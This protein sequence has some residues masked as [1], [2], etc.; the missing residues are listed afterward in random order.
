MHRV[1]LGPEGDQPR[2]AAAQIVERR[3]G[4]VIR[5]VVDDQHLPTTV[6]LGLHG[7]DR[8]R[9]HVACRLRVG[10][11][12]LTS[13]CS[14]TSMWRSHAVTVATDAAAST[15]SKRRCNASTTPRVRASRPR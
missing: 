9:K 2:F 8:V 14:G 1:S 6:R 7:L 11:M 13:N 3:T 5:S 12:T 4:A 10:V 15:S